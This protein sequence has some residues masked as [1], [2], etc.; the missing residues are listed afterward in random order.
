[1][2]L[3]PT[4]TLRSPVQSRGK[5]RPS[6]QAARIPVCDCSRARARAR[7]R[8]RG[9]AERATGALTVYGPHICVCAYADIF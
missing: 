9:L 8:T 1:M 7:T 5:G 2:G 3:L 6:A 4:S